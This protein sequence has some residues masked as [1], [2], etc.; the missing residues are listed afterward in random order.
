MVVLMPKIWRTFG[1]IASRALNNSQRGPHAAARGFTQRTLT[2]L[3]PDDSTVLTLNQNSTPSWLN[4]IITQ[5]LGLT[6]G[7]T[8]W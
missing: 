1:R 2:V 4:A 7:R 6:G 8:V 3:F 5:V